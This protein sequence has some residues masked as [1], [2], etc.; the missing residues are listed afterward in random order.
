MNANSRTVIALILSLII[1]FLG[2]S[3]YVVLE[4][5]T[6]LEAFYMTVITIST[7]GYGEVKSLSPVGQIFTTILI[8]IGFCALA[9]IGHSLVESLLEKIW[10]KSS[11]TKKC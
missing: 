8:M 9:F 11:E 2:S 1:L 6:W 4:D 3:G 7:V 10:N 5:Y